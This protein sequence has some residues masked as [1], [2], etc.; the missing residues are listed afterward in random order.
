LAS[1]DGQKTLLE[2][3]AISYQFSSRFIITHAQPISENK[4]ALDILSFAPFTRQ[5]TDFNQDGIMVM[6]RLPA[7]AEEIAG[8]NGKSFID[9]HATKESFLREI[10]NYPVVHLAT[11]AVSNPGNST[12]PFIA[13]YPQKNHSLKIVYFS[14][15]C[16]E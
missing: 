8:L 1:G 6:N 7:S 12:A 10:N 11:H 15:K 2:S 13:F 5:G 3:T 14:M 16:M 9:S 4:K